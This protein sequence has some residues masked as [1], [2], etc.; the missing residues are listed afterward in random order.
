MKKV[1]QNFSVKAVLAFLVM[2]V[3]GGLLPGCAVVGPL[4]SLG[5]MAGFA[6]L[7]YA[8]I[9]Y[10]VGE[11][12]YEYAANDHAP[13]EVIENKIDSVVRGEAFTLPDYMQAEPAGP[14]APVMVAE[15]DSAA[16]DPALF[17]D[18]RQKRIEKLLG[19]RQEQLE[20]LELRRMAFLQARSKGD[21]LSLT[22]TAMVSSP[23]LFQGA[24]DEV[25]LD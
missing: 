25:S 11:F 3:M 5:G 6:P 9:A 18:A 22:R 17:A 14:E 15:A 21:H 1:T 13:N 20:R 12:S 2:S 8:S 7:Q 4:L 23:D 10:T 19:H 24:V 16:E